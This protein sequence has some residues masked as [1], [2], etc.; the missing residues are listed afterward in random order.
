MDTIMSTIFQNIYGSLPQQLQDL[1]F[2]ESSPLDYRHFFLS[3]TCSELNIVWCNDGTTWEL[4]VSP[5][6]CWRIVT[7][8][9]EM[10]VH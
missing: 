10:L 2:L 6:L 4:I 3:A 5:F 9:P 7:P 1:S 8:G